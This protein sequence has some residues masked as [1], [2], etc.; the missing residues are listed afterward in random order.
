MLKLLHHPISHLM[1]L[2]RDVYEDAKDCIIKHGCLPK[3]KDDTWL[4]VNHDEAQFLGDEL[5]G[6]FQS[7]S[8]SDESPRPYYPRSYMPSETLASIS[9]HWS[10][11]AQSSGSG[12][13]DSSTTF[14]DDQSK[15]ALDEHLPQDAV[16]MLFQ[17][18][19]GRYRP[20]IGAI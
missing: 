14:E 10:Q 19:V 2:V 18:F 4:L 13:K 17:K 15:L 5:N 16:E 12:L 3:I 7:M 11:V 20:A 9:S 1:S 8:S 6:F